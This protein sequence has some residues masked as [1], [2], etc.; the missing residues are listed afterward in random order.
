MNKSRLL[1]EEV[2]NFYK[3]EEERSSLTFSD[4]EKMLFETGVGI[5]VAFALTNLIDTN[6]DLSVLGNYSADVG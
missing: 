2:N 1:I 3:K 4:A 6:I 5:G